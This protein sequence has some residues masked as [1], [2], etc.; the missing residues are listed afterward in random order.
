MKAIDTVGGIV[1]FGT[2]NPFSVG[3]IGDIDRFS[4]AGNRFFA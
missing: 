1:A 2:E 4:A 3:E